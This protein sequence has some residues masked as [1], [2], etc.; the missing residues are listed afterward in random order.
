M[1]P[2]LTLT[3]KGDPVPK[4]RARTTPH[5]T[6]TPHRTREAEEKWRWTVLA[7]GWKVNRDALFGLEADFFCRTKRRSDLS[8]MLKLVEDAGNG[9][10]WA[11]DSQIAWLHATVT[12]GAADPRTEVRVYYA[13][14]Q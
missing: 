10:I 11:D 4:A 13:E 8:N 6:Y 5:G 7:S 1:T 3:L 9:M 14:A 2:V 12:R